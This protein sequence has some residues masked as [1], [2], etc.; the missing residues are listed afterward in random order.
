MRRHDRALTEADTLRVI[1]AAHF[2]FLTTVG[3]DG[4]PYGVPVNAVYCDGVLYFHGTAQKS[5]KAQ[6]IAATPYVSLTFVAYE[7]RIGEEHSVDYASAVVE[8]RAELVTD[9]AEREK[10]FLAICKAHAAGPTAE[11]HRTYARQ[12]G[13]FASVWRVT[14]DTMSGKSRSWPHISGQLG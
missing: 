3:E 6:N 11:E 13:D 5:R 7:K 8:G 1:K 2:A 10:A 14:V 9:E 12:G 4:R